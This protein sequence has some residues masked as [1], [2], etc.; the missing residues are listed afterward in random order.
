[1]RTL[2]LQNLIEHRA[3]SDV[4]SEQPVATLRR[5]GTD[6]SLYACL[7]RVE[8]Y[9]YVRDVTHDDRD[10]IAVGVGVASAPLV[11]RHDGRLQVS[12]RMNAQ[13]A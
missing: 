13:T 11:E 5:L 2:T 12:H 1:M 4:V 8:P 9:G 6:G 10:H 3:C 7:G